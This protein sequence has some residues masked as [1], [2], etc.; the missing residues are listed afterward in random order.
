MNQFGAGSGQRVAA[1]TVD[2]FADMPTL[3]GLALRLV[4]G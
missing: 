3:N 1:Y 4:R 2:Q